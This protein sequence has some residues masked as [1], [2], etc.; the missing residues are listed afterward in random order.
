M[1]SIS[2]DA[3][4]AKSGSP[5][6]STIWGS[7]VIILS[8]VSSCLGFSAI[9]G[10]FASIISIPESAGVKLNTASLRLLSA[11]FSCLSPWVSCSFILRSNSVSISSSE[12]SLSS[13]AGVC[14]LRAW[15]LACSF[16]LS[17]SFSKFDRY[18]SYVSFSSSSSNFLRNSSWSAPDI[19]VSVSC[20]L[21]IESSKLSR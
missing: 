2:F 6:S 18:S 3:F 17:S 1:S 12:A 10:M 16:S 11:L 8:G 9:S 19:F 13:G 20:S 5:I 7:F 15:P 21:F 14:T 4:P